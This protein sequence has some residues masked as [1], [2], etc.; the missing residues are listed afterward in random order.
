MFHFLIIPL[1]FCIKSYT[2]Q[3]Y[4]L[5]F[6]LQKFDAIEGIEIFATICLGHSLIVMKN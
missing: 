3:A 5:N 6:L 2:S 1:R 4:K